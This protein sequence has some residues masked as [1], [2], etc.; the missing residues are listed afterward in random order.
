MSSMTLFVDES[1]RFEPP[2]PGRSAHWPCGRRLVGGVVLAGDPGEA[3]ASAREMLEDALAAI[4][5]AWWRGEV[6]GKWFRHAPTL[7]E[8]LLAQPDVPAAYH[9]LATETR[10]GVDRSRSRLFELGNG[11]LQSLRR[12]LG[13]RLGANGA[14]VLL[15]AEHG[16]PGERDL[17][18]SVPFP[19]MLSALLGQSAV[20]AARDW[21][22]PTLSSVVADRG[23]LH[24]EQLAL[25]PWA[26]ALGVPSLPPPQVARASERA[27]LQIADLIVHALGPGQGQDLHLTDDDA[28]K[29]TR[30]RVERELASSFGVE[31]LWVVEHDA[32]AVAHALRAAVEAR[33]PAQQTS[34]LAALR[35]LSPKRPPGGAFPAAVEWAQDA[36]FLEHRS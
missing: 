20:W 4:D 13:R 26:R 28:A 6:S 29:R 36:P 27:G 10:K 35:A 15:A 9:Q 34:T 16:L 14:R 5:L 7:A 11:W 3:E 22:S 23:G 25:G 17:P 19:R 31:D 12:Q 33:S 24:P 30:A 18:A 1:G 8:Q 32:F 2:K 21:E